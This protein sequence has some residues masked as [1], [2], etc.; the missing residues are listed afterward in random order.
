M[1]T[2]WRS[3][4]AVF[5]LTS[6]ALCT[7]SA[8]AAYVG[9]KYTEPGTG[10]VLEYNVFVPTGYN[11]ANKYPLMVVMHAAGGTLPRTLSS[12]GT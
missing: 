11:P 2:L 1:T 9:N 12:S 6:V 7:G 5:V 8:R 10:A 3:L 4:V